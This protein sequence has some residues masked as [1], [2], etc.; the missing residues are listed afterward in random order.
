MN[1][2]SFEE[3]RGGGKKKEEN[4]RTVHSLRFLPVCE[5]CPSRQAGS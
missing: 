5:A 4:I 3:E 1:E 2:S